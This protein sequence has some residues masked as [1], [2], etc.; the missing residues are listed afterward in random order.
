MQFL[1][2]TDW[3]LAD[4]WIL[5]ETL[6]TACIQIPGFY[7][8]STA[9]SQWNRGRPFGGVSILVAPSVAGAWLV[10]KGENW[11]I[12][13]T[14]ECFIVGVYFSPSGSD[15][16]MIERLGE[17]LALIPADKPIILAGD[18]NARIDTVPLPARTQLLLNCL[19][20]FGLWL[21]SGPTPL[22]YRSRQGDSTIDLIASSLPVER[23]S[24]PELVAG[25]SLH[26]IRKHKPVRS[27][28][29]VQGPVS[30]RPP[31]PAKLSKW[32]DLPMIESALTALCGSPDWP[33]MEIHGMVRAV[34]EVVIQAI[35][36]APSNLR[37]AKP[38]FNRECYEARKVL[39]QI[40]VLFTM[41]PVMRPLYIARRKEYKRTLRSARVGWQE[42]EERRMLKEAEEKPYSYGRTVGRTVICPIPAERMRAHFRDIAGGVSTAPTG[43]P[44]LP[45]PGRSGDQLYWS[46]RMND[47]F[48]VEEVEMAIRALPSGKAEGPDRLRY[49]H[50]KG[51]DGLTA[52]LT[53]I[54]NRCLSEACFPRDWA[55]CLMI[56][57][58]K[59]KG[60]LAEPD[61]WRG[62]SKK[63][64]MG[65][66]FAS[67]LAKRLLRFLTNCGLL[68]PEQHGF[69]PGR[70]TISAMEVMM[71]HL[72][73]SLREGGAPVY[74]LFVDFRA[75]F[76]TASRT[77]IINTL[78]SCG[79]S[80]QFLE[81]INAMLAPNM[82]KLFDGLALL[83][84]FSQDTGLP[85]GDTI[86]S[87][88]FVVLLLGLPG[89]VQRRAEG[90][91]TQLYADD[92]LLMHL[93]LERLREAARAV[94]QFAAERGLTINWAKTKILKF[95]RGGPRAA[96]DIFNIDGV[97]VPFVPT[98][99]YL[100][101]TITVTASTFTKHLID[102]KARAITAIN[103]LRP[104]TA[105]SLVTAV[106]LFYSNIAPIA[107]YG[108][109]VFWDYLKVS[110]FAILDSVLF[111][112]LK[113]VLGVSPFTRSRLILLLTG[114]KLTTECLTQMFKLT[115]TPNAV[116]YLGVMERKLDSIDPAFLD[117]PAMRDKSWMS[118]AS[119]NRSA[120]CRHAVHGFHHVFCATDGFHEPEG[121]CMCH[122][123]G[124][125][126]S[127]YH[128]MECRASPFSSITQLAS[129]N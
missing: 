44:P 38:W 24:K 9:A 67:L 97:D 22:T 118:S 99:C 13:G 8:Y 41:Q 74:A 47:P 59:G 61:A 80:G 100:G 83:P 29:R 27:M 19:G 117:T 77:A 111:T 33:S 49:E 51:S 90:T 43:P 94:M 39:I 85:Q 4:I 21:C 37:K 32:A 125:Q 122:F 45:C 92:L 98:F 109:Q 28:V 26:L 87:L 110:D 127:T 57:I 3:Q 35:P 84:E 106:S 105:L 107:Y 71:A 63:A 53:T 123:C 18:L 88:L 95:R 42:K 23:V 120:V 62:I 31:A 60:D 104:L 20:E 46:G 73:A 69:L 50:L 76:N 25:H 81:L 75:A 65:K 40:Y 17:I 6:D 72:K 96:A 93:L 56:L 34:V 121:G 70:S 52:A 113:R 48:T 5:T 116:S 30:A 12:V 126:C 86:S 55:E 11:V 102:R 54:F 124:D 68:P 7:T 1:P 119:V 79:V 82:V 10:Q 129:A 101:F 58:P 14:P 108:V 78:S 103:M 16:G 114:V 2:D 89:F 112:Y 15:L 128:A 115:Q 36:V 66:L 91:I 64:V